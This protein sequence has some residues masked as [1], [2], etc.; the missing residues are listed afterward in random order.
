MPDA[1]A[2]PAAHPAAPQFGAYPLLLATILAWGCN[3]PIMKIGL[4]YVTPLQFTSA[5]LLLGAACMFAL[6]LLLGRLKLPRRRDLPIVFSVG[7][8]QI[9]LFLALVNLAL[10]HVEAGRSAILAYTTP[11]WVTPLSLFFLGERLTR[12]KVAGLVLGILG[13]AILFNPLGFDW[14]NRDVLIGN[15][16]LMLAA[17]SWALVIVQIRGHS[18][19]FSPLELAPWQFLL[20]SIPVTALALWLDGDVA[21]VWTGTLV[22]ILAYNGPIATAFA[23]WAAVT[24]NRALPAITTSLGFLGVP[25]TGFIS[26]ALILGEPLTVT[27]IAGLGL[28]VAG[29]ALASLAD[30]RPGGWSRSLGKSPPTA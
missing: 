19:S 9:G 15:A 23:F 16:L 5:R 28:I 7:L 6:V 2:A 22:G 30:W 27:G 26:S 10:V 25:V 24:V 8:V 4:R 20:G 14:G 11:L 21:I 12:V 18:H 13:V 17:L 1:T 29:L 3:W